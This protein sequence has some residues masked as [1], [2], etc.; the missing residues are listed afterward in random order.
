MRN[1]MVKG[2]GLAV[3][4]VVLAA[5]LLVTACAVPTTLPSGQKLAKFGGWRSGER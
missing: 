1:R 5:L 2:K 4:G 3:V